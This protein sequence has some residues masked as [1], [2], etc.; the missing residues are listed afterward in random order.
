MKLHLSQAGS[1][2]IFIRKYLFHISQFCLIGIFA[3][4]A[5]TIFLYLLDWVT[6]TRSHHPVIIWYLPIAGFIIGWFF[7][8][9]GKEISKGSNLILDEIHKPKRTLPFA[10]A[11]LVLFGTLCTHLFGGSSGR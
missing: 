2:F 1:H 10:M 7:H 4:F 11:P 5:A 6:T 8:Y 3:G 9:F